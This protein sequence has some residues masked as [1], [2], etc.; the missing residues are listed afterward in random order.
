MH[1]QLERCTNQDG[2]D[3]VTAWHANPLPELPWI[4][5]L[6][7]RKCHA[8]LQAQGA[9][10]YIPVSNAA[11]CTSK[12]VIIVI[13]LPLAQLGCDGNGCQH[14]DLTELLIIL[15]SLTP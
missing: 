11:Q 13:H 14:E 15:L 2:M 4:V 1:T 7:G 10:L 3:L 12:G 9:T 8:G 5:I 6:S